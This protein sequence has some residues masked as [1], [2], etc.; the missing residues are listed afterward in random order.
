M[1]QTLSLHQ[2]VDSTTEPKF[3]EAVVSRPTSS[4]RRSITPPTAKNKE[5]TAYAKHP[6]RI[7]PKINFLVVAIS[8]SKAKNS[9][10]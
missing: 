7:Q 5:S 8:I 4:K 3:S 2:E 9:E 6:T 1:T 10:N